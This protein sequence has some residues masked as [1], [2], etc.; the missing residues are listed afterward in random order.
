MRIASGRLK[1]TGRGTQRRSNGRS[2][3]LAC[4]VKLRHEDMPEVSYLEAA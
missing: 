3:D 2:R 1:V 4:T